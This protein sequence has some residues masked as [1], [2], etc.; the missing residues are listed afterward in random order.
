MTGDLQEFAGA[1]SV[2]VA[3]ATGS[4]GN[5]WVL[6]DGDQGQSSISVVSTSGT[7]EATYQIPTQNAN[8]QGLVLGSDGNL[9][10]VES[11]V[12]QI[13]SITPTGQITEYP[14]PSP[15]VN[16]GDSAD[17]DPETV[18]ADPTALVEGPDGAIWFTESSGQ[19]I[20]RITTA[21][22]LTQIA[23]PGLQPNSIAV[24]SDGNIWFTDDSYNDTVDRINPDQSISTFLIPTAFAQPNDLINGP[25]GALYFTEGFNQ[26]IG[27]VTM[28]GTVTETPIKADMSSP[29]QLVLDSAGNLWVTGNN[30]GL[31]EIT[32]RGVTNTIGPPS[33]TVGG[34]D[35]V[36]VGPDGA[37]WFTDTGRD[38]IG[39]I[40]PSSVTSAPTDHILTAVGQTN[41]FSSATNSLEFTGSVAT[42]YD[43]NMTGVLSDYTATVDWGDGSTSAG[44]ITQTNPGTFNIDGDHVY[45][46][47]GTYT[48]TITVADT[49][50]NV[51]PQPDQTSTT[52][53]VYVNNQPVPII[54]PVG[55]VTFNPIPIVTVLAPGSVNTG[56]TGTPKTTTPAPAPAK[57]TPKIPPV[58]T[59]TLPDIKAVVQLFEKNMIQSV[60]N[61]AKVSSPFAVKPKTFVMV[62]LSKA[63]PKTIK[64]FPV[65]PPVFTIH[66]VKLA[67][68]SH[69]A[70]THAAARRHR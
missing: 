59:T 36:T 69:P 24:G 41:P 8:P 10:F 62:E 18:A 32:P 49:N 5:L 55:P 25:D 53:S 30:V 23:T 68:K 9:W 33:T 45:A 66:P 12:D 64:P 31:V 40:D 65:F 17:P 50:P 7:V 15:T 26:A 56:S 51:T 43:S 70:A 34:L 48:V 42:L 1:F 13:G 14:I 58:I 61:K 2:P 67:V 6:N 19:A 44:T 22:V 47:S 4:D 27:R 39:R 54:G 20:G 3:I 28:D 60:L 37:I 35:G 52:T 21:G 63:A 57:T 29:N 38:Q 11:G 46:Q 16:E